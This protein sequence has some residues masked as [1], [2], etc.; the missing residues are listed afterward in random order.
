MW[1]ARS[2]F[3][4]RG[5]RKGFDR[6]LCYS[7]EIGI[8][9]LVTKGLHFQLF[10]IFLYIR[11]T[12]VFVFCFF[13]FFNSHT[14]HENQNMESEFGNPWRVSLGI[15]CECTVSEVTGF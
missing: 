10:S 4:E 14:G 5:Q 3:L 13:C 2:F 8:G 1:C 11:S 6:F 15:S 9:V 12:F 7:K